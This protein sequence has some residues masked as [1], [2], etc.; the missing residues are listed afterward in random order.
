MQKA[1]GILVFTNVWIALGAALATRQTVVLLGNDEWATALTAGFAT[2]F[3]YNFQ[4]LMKLNNLDGYAMNARNQWLAKHRVY[5]IA[6]T[7]L[8]GAAS[9]VLA[10]QLAW[11][12]LA[13]M[14]PALLVALAYAI[15]VVPSS[16]GRQALRDLPGAKLYLIGLVWTMVTVGM[17]ALEGRTLGRDLPA[18]VLM[19]AERFAFITALAIPFDIRDLVYDHPRQR[20]LAQ[21]FGVRRARN[22]SMVWL[23]PFGVS[24]FLNFRMG[25]YGP[26]AALALLVS[27]LISLVVL[28]H[29]VKSEGGEHHARSEWYYSVCVDGLIV[30]QWL[31][32]WLVVECNVK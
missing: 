29:T 23:V 20:T 7:A 28:F 25:I 6:L 16:F 19:A 31:L 15:R 2:L 1:A 22:L 3:I 18:I 14:V 30:L 32:V 8:A 4:R 17:P 27:A 13:L 5:L 24:V 21:R 10:L 9:I 11:S 12:T 26:A